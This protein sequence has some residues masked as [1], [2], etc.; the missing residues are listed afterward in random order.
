MSHAPTVLI[1]GGAG[2]IGSHAALASLEAGWNVV[3][4]DDLSRGF[5]AALPQDVRLVVG[6]VG[7]AR[8]VERTLAEHDISA[9]MHFAGSIIVPESVA[10]PGFY[11]QNNTA[12]S[13]VLMR[14]AAAHPIEAFLFSS[15]A[16]VYGMTAAAQVDESA[17]TVPISPYGWSKLMTEQMLADLSCAH[18]LRYG[19]LRYFNVAGADP[20]GRIGQRTANAT[21]LLKVALETASGRRSVLP[22]YGADY[23]T[24]DGTCLRDF[25]HVSDL[26][27]AHVAS[28]RRLLAGGD[29][30][31]ANAGYGRGASVLEVIRAVERVTGRALP[32][33]VQARRPGDPAMVV[34]DSTRLKA[35]TGWRPRFDDLDMIVGTAWRWEQKL[36]AGAGP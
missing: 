24:P 36:L 32:A 2:Y 27:D 22:I 26:A 10:N 30:F 25:I 29:S 4:L 34:A 11:Y 18:G 9:I 15:T 1:T 17:P 12:N 8:L 14:A 7:D 3:V 19:V 5:R 13:L 21:H 20:A 31:L 35:L 6:D 16:A 28:L 23:S 33:E